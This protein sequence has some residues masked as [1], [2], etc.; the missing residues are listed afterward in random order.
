MKWSGCDVEKS[1]RDEDRMVYD[2]QREIQELRKEIR[3][4]DSLLDDLTQN[5]EVQVQVSTTTCLTSHTLSR[6]GVARIYAA[7]LHSVVATNADNF[8]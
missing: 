7:R 6:L 1:Q 5:N 2:H 4:K 3:E 8:F